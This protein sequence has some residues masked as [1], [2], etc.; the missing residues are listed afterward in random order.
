MDTTKAHS[1]S[2][3]FGFLASKDRSANNC[4]IGLA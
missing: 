2:W 3:T 4:D 1:L